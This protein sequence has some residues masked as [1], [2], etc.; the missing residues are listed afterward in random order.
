M[1]VDLESKNTP[2]EKAYRAA[3]AKFD[4][5]WHQEQATDATTAKNWYAAVFHYALLMQHDPDQ[6]SCYAGLQSSFEKLN[7]QFEQEQRD[8]EPHLAM[9]VREAL[10][11]APRK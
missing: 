1:L 2:D 3:K 8:L 11:L 9:V 6:A 4:P 10:K 5:V 7:S